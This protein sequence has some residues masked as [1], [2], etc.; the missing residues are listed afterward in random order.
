MLQLAFFFVRMF[1]KPYSVYEQTH[2]NVKRVLYYAERVLNE[3]NPPVRDTAFK[4]I[5]LWIQRSAH[6]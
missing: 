4:L 2:E 1:Q 6:F 3:E 5:A